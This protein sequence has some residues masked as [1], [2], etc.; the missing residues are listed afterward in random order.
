[1]SN[2]KKQYESQQEPMQCFRWSKKLRQSVRL[3]AVKQNVS[4][5]QFITRALELYLESLK[6]QG[7]GGK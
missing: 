2:Q 1:M 6:G 4:V 5:T 3:A 7:N